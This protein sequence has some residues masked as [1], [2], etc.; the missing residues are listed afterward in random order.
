MSEARTV[1]SWPLRTALRSL[2]SC[3]RW[4]QTEREHLNAVE[5]AAR[6]ALMVP[7]FGLLLVVLRV[8]AR[9]REP[10]EIMVTTRTGDRFRCHPPDLIQLYLW[11]FGVWEPDLTRFLQDRLQPNDGFIDVG[12]NI[13]VFSMLAARCVGPTGRV[14]AIEASPDVFLDL[15][16]TLTLNPQS[17]NVRCVN[18]AAAAV[19]G[20]LVIYR[21]PDK[22]TGLTTTV[23]ARGFEGQ[24]SV[25]ALPLDDLLLPDEVRTARIVKIDVE[26]AEEGVIAGMR[27][28]IADGRED[29]EILIEL[30]PHWWADAGR[31]ATDVLKPLFDA[32]FH[33]YEMENNYWPWRYMWPRC[34]NRPSRCTRSLD[35]HGD[36][37]DLVLSRRDTDYL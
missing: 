24:G 27:R 25:D 13:G 29:V 23:R 18:K 36:R 28:V 21:G 7:P 11:L 19:P 15:R 4:V 3:L 16:D 8:R 14:V 30:S 1:M 31:R 9:F 37:L 20:S 12:A 32:G 2:R 6:L 34:V 10:L 33:A 35:E 26:G 5:K 17:A 22:N